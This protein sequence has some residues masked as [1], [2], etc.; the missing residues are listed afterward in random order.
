MG[1]AGLQYSRLIVRVAASCPLRVMGVRHVGA[2]KHVTSLHGLGGCAP[3]DP[4]PQAS[5]LRDHSSAQLE[6]RASLHSLSLHSLHTSTARR[7]SSSSEA[8][9]S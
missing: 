7:D 1:T 5:T 8:P 3:P 2:A 9:T 6:E 4:S